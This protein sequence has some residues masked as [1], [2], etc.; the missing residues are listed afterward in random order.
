MREQWRER[1]HTEDQRDSPVHSQ[2]Q[3]HP[4]F[5][6]PNPDAR[7]RLVT[8]PTHRI[9]R[10]HRTLL[11]KATKFWGIGYAA[12]A[13]G[14]GWSVDT[15]LLHLA[16][17]HHHLMSSTS[18]ISGSPFAPL[19]DHV[20][21]VSR[22]VCVP[23]PGQAIGAFT[24]PHISN[25]FWAG[26]VTLTHPKGL[27]PRTS[28]GLQ[29]LKEK[30]LGLSWGVSLSGKTPREQ[31]HEPKTLRW[32][33]LTTPRR[34]RVQLLLRRVPPPGVL[35]HEPVSLPSHPAFYFFLKPVCLGSLWPQGSPG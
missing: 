34:P 3:G 12:L 25:L 19:P 5:S 4:G 21:Q 6:S 14:E 23:L 17:V 2:H 26:R 27:N 16:R 29:S 15:W 11:L 30:N 7:S 35:S 8:Q 33:A 24:L 22:C 31:S 13:N 28:A 20:T 32:Q 18:G 9:G 1:C 10:I